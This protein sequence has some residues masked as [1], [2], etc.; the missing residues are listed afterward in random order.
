M[1]TL[2]RSLIQCAGLTLVFVPKP[3]ISPHEA[4]ARH[5]MRLK[6]FTRRLGRPGS[7]LGLVLFLAVPAI[8]QSKPPKRDDRDMDRVQ[9]MITQAKKEAEEFSKSGGKPDDAKHPNLKW[10]ATLWRYRLKHPGT[11]AT[12]AATTQVFTLLNRSNRISEMQAKADALKLNDPAWEQVIN[13]FLF[14]SIKTKDYSYLITKAEA[15]TQSAVDPNIKAR[16]RFNIGE[17][18]WKKG[19]TEQ[20][21]INFQTV[22]DQYPKTTYAEEAEGNVREI[23]FLNVGQPA[24]EF[25]RTTINGDRVSTASFKGKTLVL[26]FWGTY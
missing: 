24:P 5:N 6:S 16:A 14:A 19:D 9:A 23:K 7:L 26:K 8:A 4:Y 25:D 12:L 13:T 17:A 18:Y 20:A 15:L 22:V 10:A 21:R 11:P 3:E 1:N 2:E